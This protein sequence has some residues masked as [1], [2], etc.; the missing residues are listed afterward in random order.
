MARGARWKGALDEER[1]S[2]EGARVERV[3]LLLLELSYLF[4][5]KPKSILNMTIPLYIYFFLIF[6]YLWINLVI[7]VT[8]CGLDSIRLAAI[9]SPAVLKQTGEIQ[10]YR[11]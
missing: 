4:K 7:L 5:T 6:L 11:V 9:I 2:M 10:V 8:A 3:N 1:R